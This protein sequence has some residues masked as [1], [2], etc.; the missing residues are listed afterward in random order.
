MKYLL[1]IVLVFI[2]WSVW[3][4]RSQASSDKQIPVS[5]APQNMLA[6]L[7]CGVNFP[8]ND[9]VSDQTGSY[10]CAAHRTAAGEER[11]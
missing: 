3:K 11:V 4:K 8:E 10:C 1:L 6:C 9:G 5:P 2:V 7:H